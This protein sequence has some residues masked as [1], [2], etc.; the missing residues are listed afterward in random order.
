MRTRRDIGGREE[1]FPDQSNAYLVEK[2]QEGKR[3]EGEK[4]HG[5]DA[6]LKRKWETG[7]SGK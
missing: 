4:A 1:R 6:S 3:E 7:D 5:A 2:I